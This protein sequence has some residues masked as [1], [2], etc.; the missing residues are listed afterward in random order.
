MGRRAVDI[1]KGWLA[2]V[3]CLVLV[4]S[5]VAGVA[6]GSVQ[7]DD[8]DE[9]TRSPLVRTFVDEQGRQIDEVIVPGQLP[10]EILPKVA[11]V[12]E[13]NIAAGTNTLANVPAFDWCHGCSATSAAMM[14]GYY[15]QPAQGYTNM[16]AGSTNGGLCP[17]TNVL[18]GANYCSLSA[19]YQ[20]GDGLG[21]KGH[22]NDYWQGPAGS[23]IDPYFVGPW[24][25]HGYANC[26]ADY[27]GTSQYENWKNPDGSTRFYYYSSNAALCDYSACESEVP[28]KRDGAHGLKLFLQSRGYDVGA[29]GNCNQYIYGFNTLPAGFTWVQFKAE[30]DAGRPVLI[31]TEDIGPP[32]QGH[33]MLA[34]GYND[35]PPQTIYLHDTWD[36][37]AHSMTWGGV[38]GGL[39]HYAV[40]YIHPTGGVPAGGTDEIGIY[41]PTTQ[42]FYLRA[43][44]GSYTIIKFGALTTNKPITGDWNGNGTDEIGIYDPNTQKFYLRASDGSYS[45]IRFGSYTTNLPITGDWN[46]L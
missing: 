21:V 14:V 45:V 4:L 22:V 9:P 3:I 1:K 32:P 39:T 19:T 42:K 12:P 43:S 31:H 24:L 38:Y 20:G 28:A 25:E 46:G 5:A 40:T 26:T 23:T 27:M 34:Y 8:G 11:Q 30:I 33:T 6:T 36:Y 2:V 29:S 18:W 15:D 37:S 13:P 17:T 7:A 41:D 44:D 35:G 10:P 16:Y